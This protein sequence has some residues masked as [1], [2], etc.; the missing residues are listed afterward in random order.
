MPAILK[1]NKKLIIILTLILT[2]PLTMP[3][4]EILGNTLFY[5]GKYV[6]TWVRLIMSGGVC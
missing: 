1:K 2:L 5:A 4:L 3:I 6:G